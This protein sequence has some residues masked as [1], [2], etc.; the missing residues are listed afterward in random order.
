M[1]AALSLT[2]RPAGD[3]LRLRWQHFTDVSS[4]DVSSNYFLVL[5]SSTGQCWPESSDGLSPESEGTRSFINP[6]THLHILAH[7][8]ILLVL[9]CIY[10]SCEGG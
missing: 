10:N 9:L 1:E 4:T 2:Q 7:Q 5:M 8:G 6:P 3:G